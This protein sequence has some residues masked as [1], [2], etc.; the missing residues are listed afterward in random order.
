MI[1]RLTAL[2]VALAAWCCPG[3]LGAALFNN[4]VS[5]G[6]SLQ[7]DP[8]GVRSPVAAEHIAAR[9]GASW[10]KLAVSGSTSDDLIDDGQHTSA[11][12]NFGSGDAAFLWIGGNDFFYSYFTVL[13]GGTLQSTLNNA[14]ANVET[15]LATLTAAD[16]DVVL[17][18]L[19]DMS[20]V[21]FVETLA[22]GNRFL[23]EYSRAS[24]EWATRLESLGAQ[25]GAPVVDVFGL[26]NER[27][28]DPLAFSILD[29]PVNLGPGNGGQFDIFADA[30][31]PSAYVQGLIASAA[32]EEINAY[33]D[34][35]GAMPLA[36]LTVPELA[37]LI[38]LVAGDFDESGA[39]GAADLAAWE[40]GFGL[41]VSGGVGTHVTGDANDDDRVTGA[42]FLI[43]QRQ[44]AAGSAANATAVPEPRSIFVLAVLSFLAAI[45]RRGPF[46]KGNSLP[47][48]G[49][50]R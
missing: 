37:E 40:G 46:L 48:R 39:A 6:D 18:N 35:N 27:L 16:M 44:T 4:I 10:T 34:P 9:M 26:F 38:G 25:Y 45:C 15:A 32:I 7:D 50:P 36:P 28:A 19:P 21:P 42:D 49:W 3:V 43:W 8:D 2:G 1:R 30:F 22:P 29:H 24:G 11:A 31:H 5:L 23:D 41:G 33:F 12:A 47:A 17:F 14:A 20:A 13:F